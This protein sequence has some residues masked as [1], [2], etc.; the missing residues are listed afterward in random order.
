[1]A[2]T[3]ERIRQVLHHLETNPTERQL[4]TVAKELRRRRLPEFRLRGDGSTL[5]EI[6]S[7]ASISR[8]MMLMADLG[9][10]R[11]TAGQ[12]SFRPSDFTYLQTDNA[13]AKKIDQT[14]KNLLARKGVRLAEVNDAIKKI[15]PP[16]VPDAPT[17]YEELGTQA[18]DLTE[19]MFA[20][21]LFL[22][23]CAGMSLSRTIHVHYHV[24]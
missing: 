3:Y 17:V 5:D 8:L 22:L 7:E 16:R 2:T 19:E 12:L 6:M 14:A 18:T 20:K 13:Y 9:L 23:A 10:I 11:L 21:L 1:M 15:Q 24:D 4:S